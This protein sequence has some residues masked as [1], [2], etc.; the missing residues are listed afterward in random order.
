VLRKQ[1]ENEIKEAK[2]LKKTSVVNSLLN[3][4][5]FTIASSTSIHFAPWILLFQQQPPTHN[6][7]IE[8]PYGHQIVMNATEYF[9]AAQNGA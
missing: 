1:F 2:S 4:S 9:E 5:S 6:T 7:S 3:E 8:D